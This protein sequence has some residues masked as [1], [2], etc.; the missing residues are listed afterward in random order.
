MGCSYG[1]C[2]PGCSHLPGLN[3]PDHTLST[4][5]RSEDGALSTEEGC[6]PLG[7]SRCGQQSSPLISVTDQATSPTSSLTLLYLFLAVTF[8]NSDHSS[9]LDLSDGLKCLPCPFPSTLL[10]GSPDELGAPTLMHPT[11]SHSPR[12]SVTAEPRLFWQCSLH[13]VSCVSSSSTRTWTREDYQ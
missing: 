7:S 1:C 11:C 4:S 9:P 3:R 5:L 12:A 8:W 13:S 10:R 6:P 2:V